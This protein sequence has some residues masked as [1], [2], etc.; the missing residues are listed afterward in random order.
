MSDG[1]A[2][3]RGP[4]GRDEAGRKGRSLHREAYVTRWTGRRVRELADTAYLDTALKKGTSF[5]GF[6][7]TRH[8]KPAGAAQ[9]ERQTTVRS[10]GTVYQRHV[11]VPRALFT[12]PPP[13]L[14][15]LVI[16]EAIKRKAQAEIQRE[17][18]S[19]AMYEMP[20][21]PERNHDRGADIRPVDSYE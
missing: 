9:P 15:T 17:A 11:A 7:M 12:A 18:L 1:A 2:H 10:V 6:A 20:V 4:T 19:E 5:G 8:F 21:S 14:L 13:D 16:A 3:G